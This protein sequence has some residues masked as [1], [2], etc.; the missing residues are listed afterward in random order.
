MTTEQIQINNKIKYTELIGL[1]GWEYQKAWRKL[2][3]QSVKESQKKIRQKPG[4]YE[5]RHKKD[6]CKYGCSQTTE[7]SRRS[8]HKATM[9]RQLWGVVED[10]VLMSGKHT[11]LELVVILGRSIRSIQRRKWRIRQ[12]Q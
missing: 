12:E 7:A 1:K 8:E 3:P 6:I 5:L 9:A 11:E 4:Y 10:D 2:N